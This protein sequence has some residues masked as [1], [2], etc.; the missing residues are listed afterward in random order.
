MGEVKK[1]ESGKEHEFSYVKW[2][3]ELT[4]KSIQ[5]AGGKGAN[6]AEIYN[7]ELPVPAAFVV[8]TNAY[9]DFLKE[10][11]LEKEIY[12]ILSKVD[13]EK[14]EELK[15]EARKIREMIEGKEIPE[16]IKEEIL[17]S[18]EHL[19]VDDESL[20]GASEDAL[21]ILNRA[22]EPVF[23]AVRSSANSEDSP[24]ASF[25]G[26]QKTFLNVKGKTALIDSVKGCWASLFSARSIYYRV[27]N[28][29][30]HEST[31]IA[32]VVQVMLNSDKS[33]VI[34]TK[35]PVE[36]TDNV[37]IEA[38]FGL[39]EGIVS[40]MIAPDNYV[41][42]R[43]LKL[44]NK[45]ISDKK[46]ALVK[47][48][49]GKTEKVKLTSERSNSE[50]LTGYE[51]K[52]LAQYSLEIEEHYNKPQDIEFAI[53]S[54]KFYI[55]QTRPITTLDKRQKKQEI[56]GE[57]ILSGLA[58]SPGIGSGPVK[59]IKDLNELSKIKKGDVLVTEMTN[60]DM[61]VAMQKSVAIIT[62]EGGLTAHAAIVSREMGIPA[63][64]GTRTATTTLKEGDV[65]TV[66]GFTGK[67]YKGKTE[68]KQVE[69]LPIEEGT[70]TKIKVILDLPN[71][72]DRAAK[73]KV[74][75][76]GLTRVEGII[77]ESGKHPQYFLKEKKMQDY[78]DV[79]YKGVKK[80]A[81]HFEEVWVRTSDLRSD[82]YQNLEGASK[83]IEANP[84]L[85]MHGIRASLKYPEILK[86]ELNALK[87]ITE[88]SKGEKKIGILTPQVISVEE[89]IKLK[90][91]LKEIG[92]SDARVGV[93]V[94]TPASV[95][96]IEALCDEGID[97]ASFGTNDL[98]QY[99]LAI[100]RGN[101]EVQDIY[102]EMHPAILSQLKYVLKICKEKGV[103]T[104]ICG[105]AGSKKEMVK[106][107][108]ENEIDSI[109]TN[110]DKAKEIS[111]Y[112]KEL[113][114]GETIKEPEES[115]ADEPDKEVP[116]EE[117][118]PAENEP[119]KEEIVEPNEEPEPTGEEVKEP[120]QEMEAENEPEEKVP[121]EE[122]EQEKK[123]E[124]EIKGPE[125]KEVDGD[126]EEVKE[127]VED[128]KVEEPAEET[129][130]SEEPEE[131]VEET[132]VD[133][134]PEAVEETSSEDE[135]LD[136]F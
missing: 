131:E 55:V 111:E 81:E 98:T 64:V 86:A 126:V 27:K 134:E 8:L 76:V 112:V 97:F 33:G 30:T 117:E 80:I 45:K 79:I 46:I 6:L 2:L 114:G 75:S 121:K 128:E 92:F 63:V 135:E 12:S 22:K 40:G 56:S 34:F 10:T 35:D 38:V 51:I 26:Q 17:E 44:E 52:K 16:K 78:E 18:Y 65:V 85:G 49:A 67:I 60:P 7:L 95:Q 50:V 102:N 58:A 132:I 104:S 133:D 66:N 69:I 13:T 91:V 109:S 53:D 89:I 96:I 127:P 119:E 110:A 47:N 19:N 93:M 9:N 15:K 29:F 107:L 100:D 77:A 118:E 4:R 59:I 106:F 74:K 31:S 84:M 28:K 61:V 72:A 3:S 37:V 68:S 82:E 54:G 115:V 116:K 14:T 83:D 11:G 130:V 62:D 25:A 71:F 36:Q 20:K 57:V 43:E 48:S 42:N 90:E 70:K 41:V 21:S 124:P 136:I 108:V 101:E 94:E 99:T 1:K 73:T 123:T 23:V 120:V 103:E 39:G 24:E 129:I 105:Q 87:K 113:E 125:E 88:E 122:V 5:D 32:V